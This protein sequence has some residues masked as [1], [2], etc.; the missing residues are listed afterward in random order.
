MQKKMDQVEAENR[1]IYEQ[2]KQQLVMLNEVN[3]KFRDFQETI[4]Q[5]SG[6]CEAQNQPTDIN[7]TDIVFPKM[8]ARD[9]NNLQQVR[10]SIQRAILA[11]GCDVGIEQNKVRQCIANVSNIVFGQSFT[12]EE[13][14]ASKKSKR[15]DCA[16]DLGNDR[17]QDANVNADTDA[18]P[19]IA[20]RKRKRPRNMDPNL[21]PSHGYMSHLERSIEPAAKK[22]V[23]KK[24]ASAKNVT[25][26]TDGTDHKRE[27]TM[28]TQV[29]IPEKTAD[30][31]TI[32]TNYCIDVQQSYAH[33]AAS[34]SELIINIMREYSIL[35]M[36]KI[37]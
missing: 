37:P 27:H 1:G 7:E 10:P 18:A 8:S 9:P 4:L 23:A 34:V 2:L 14:P 30:G 36:Q 28:V 32:T 31:K 15:K 21:L 17:D 6:S 26:G 29:I 20:G 13:K 19:P 22:A 5:L 25:L 12:F 24:L 11:L 16:A 3:D 35:R 33:D